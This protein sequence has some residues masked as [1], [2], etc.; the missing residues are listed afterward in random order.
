MRAER[1]INVGAPAKFGVALLTLLI[2][3]AATRSEPDCARRFELKN[4]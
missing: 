4:D 2:L 1:G 3:H